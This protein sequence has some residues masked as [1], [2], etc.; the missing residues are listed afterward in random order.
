[1]NYTDIGEGE[2]S[3]KYKSAGCAR[4]RV[5]AREGVFYNY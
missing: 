2:E 3:K 4:V 5:C 1:M